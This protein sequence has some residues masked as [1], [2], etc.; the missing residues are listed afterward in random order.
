[1]S[2]P[3]P[4]SLYPARPVTIAAH[5]PAPADAVI[6]FIADTRNDPLWCPNV[7][8]VELVEGDGGI[9]SRFRFHQHLDRGDKRIEFDVDAEVVELTETMI[10]WQ[11]KDRYQE[12]DIIM[13]VEPDGD[14]SRVTQT[15]RANFL[16]NPGLAKWAYPFIA[17]RTFRDQ[18]DQLQKHF[19]RLG[20]SSAD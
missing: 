6:A 8:S 14:G 5:I 13:T 3:P 11:I 18:F 16:K 10:R 4:T 20:N 9:G 19:E 12:R 17:K 2:T 7:D 1:V 15:T